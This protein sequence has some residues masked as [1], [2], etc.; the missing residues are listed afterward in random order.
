MPMQVLTMR[1]ADSPF[2]R[3]YADW[4]T[5]LNPATQAGLLAFPTDGKPVS[6]RPPEE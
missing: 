2:C 3:V 4:H 1:T 6:V 5:R